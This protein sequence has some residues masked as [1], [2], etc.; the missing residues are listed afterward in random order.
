MVSALFYKCYDEKIPDLNQRQ[1]REKRKR[2]EKEEKVVA[3]DNWNFYWFISQ[4][5]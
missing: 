3:I 5:A 4:F 2:R 1:E